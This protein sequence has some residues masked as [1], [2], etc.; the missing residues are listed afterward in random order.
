MKYSFNS[1]PPTPAK[2][3]KKKK[4]KKKRNEISYCLQTCHVFN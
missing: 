1:L 2:K 3:K 4:E